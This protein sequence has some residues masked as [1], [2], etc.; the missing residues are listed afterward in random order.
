MKNDRFDQIQA[1]TGLKEECGVFGIYN[2]DNDDSGRVVYYG[3]FAL[4]H[5]GQESCGIAVT[6]D[7]VVKQY[8]DMGLVPDVFTDD[9]IEKLTGKI[10]AKLSAAG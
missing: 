9:I 5:R 7:T 3:L 10:A 1:D 6:D 2:N 8:K 4:Q